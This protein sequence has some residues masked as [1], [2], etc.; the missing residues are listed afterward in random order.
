MKF[1]IEPVKSWFG[2]SRRERRSSSIL[3]L[4]I[5]FILTCRFFIP[6]KQVDL[7]ELT[8]NMTGL[9]GTSLVA[10]ADESFSGQLFHFDPNTLSHDSLIKLGLTSGEA[11]TLLKYR[12][13]G[14]KFRNPSDIRKVYGLDEAKAVKLI[15]FI[16]LASNSHDK[17][18]T[19]SYREK[20]PAV[21]INNCDSAS[22]ERLPGIGPVLSVRIIKY[23]H[24]LGGF[25]SVNQLTEVYGLSK[26]TFDLIKG[27]IFADSSVVTRID[28]NSAGFKDLSHHPYFEKYEVNAI[29]KYRELK[30]KIKN[31]SDLTDNKL[32]T[33]EKAAKLRPYLKFE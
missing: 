22:L 31:I 17:G 27:R 32:I 10:A 23:R 16:R 4:I 13:K 28:I 21:D 3:V 29:L 20:L 2:F 7:T 15:P 5:I 8:G 30:G 25:A 9:G 33:A 11:N 18:K 24:L 19:M 1:N 6:D 14:G 26:E 12:A